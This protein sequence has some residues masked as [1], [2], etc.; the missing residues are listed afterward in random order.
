MKIAKLARFLGDINGGMS[1]TRQNVPD[2]EVNGFV[3]GVVEKSTMSLDYAGLRLTELFISGRKYFLR[4][5]SRIDV[6]EEIILHL[7]RGMQVVAFQIVS[8]DL[9]LFRAILRQQE[10]KHGSESYSFVDA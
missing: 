8:G 6:G 2:G 4:G 5:A 9:V 7:E 1:G 10:F 3:R